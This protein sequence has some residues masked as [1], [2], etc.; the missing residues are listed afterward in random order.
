MATLLSNLFFQQY[1]HIFRLQFYILH[2]GSFPKIIKNPG[3]FILFKIKIF[4]ITISLVKY[5]FKRT[6]L[7]RKFLNKIL[8]N[9]R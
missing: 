5:R 8:N 2:F 6:I 4:K 1:I 7:N 3:F 9:L